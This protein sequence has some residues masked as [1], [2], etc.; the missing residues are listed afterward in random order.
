[1]NLDL[2]RLPPDFLVG[3]GEMGKLIGAMDWNGTP[4]GPIASWPQSLRTTVSLC[5][6]SN[7]PILIAWGPKHV[8]IYNDGYWPICGGKHPTSMGQ[9]FT[10]CLASAWPAIGE[11]FERALAGEASY[12]ENQ[13]MFLDRSGYLEETFFTFSFSPI[14]DEAGEVGGLFHPVTE[15]TGKML[16]ERRT[17]ALR[18]VSVR[19]AMA[20]TTADVFFSAA[21]TLAAYDL[22]LPFVLFYVLNGDKAELVAH[23]GCV[24]GNRLAPLSLDLAATAQESWPL[25][26]AAESATSIQVDDLAPRIDPS[27]C[28]PYPERPNTAFLLPIFPPGSNQAVAVMVAGVSSRLPLNDMYRTFVELIAGTV[29]AAVANATAYQDGRRRAEVLAE[30]DRTKTAF[31]SNIS[32]EF[33]TPL[34]LILGPVEDA[35][36]DTASSLSVG[37]R[38]RLE[39]V[40]RNALRLLKLVNALLDFSR[41]EAGRMRA[42]FEPIDLAT[43]TAELASNFDWLC[44]KAGLRLMIDCPPLP[45]KIHVDTEMWEKIV[46]NLISNAFKFTLCGEIAVSLHPVG[47]DSVELAVRDT[48][49]GIP[50]H[51]LPRLFERFHR[52]EGA[53][54][55]SYEGSGIGL[56]LVY[57]LV[58]LHNGTLLVESEVG[59]GS[60]FRV[61]LPSGTAHLPAD[62]IGSPRVDV[63]SGVR[64][65]AFLEEAMHWLPD[66][67][68]AENLAG[69]PQGISSVNDSAHGEP[70]PDA[71]RPRIILADDNADMRAYVSRILQA[72]GYDVVAVPD[73]EAALC[74]CTA[75]AV[76]DLV[77]TD[78]MMP[79]LDGFG[80]LRALRADP[81][82]EGLLVILLSARAGEEARVEGLVAGADDYLV[83]PFSAR[84]LL[85]RVEGSIRLARQRRQAAK[86][87]REL[88]T[89]LVAERGR[90]ALRKSEA[91]RLISEEKYRRLLDQARE[92]ILVL[93]ATGRILEANRSAEALFDRSQSMLLSST[94]ESLLP[95]AQLGELR[96]LLAVDMDELKE[97]HLPHADGR[98][99]HVEISTTRVR[100]GEQDI[101]LLIAR[102]ITERLLLEQQLRQAQK[103]EVVGQLTGGIA[104]DFNNILTVIIG[105]IELIADGVA[106]DAELTSSAVSIE[107][108]ADRGAQLTQRML[109]FAR[110][111]PLRPQVVD[112]SE[113]MIRMARI[114]RRT[115]GEDIAVKVSP[116]VGLWQAVA[117]PS[118]VED[119][120][121]NLAVNARDAMPQGGHLLF[122]TANAS[123][124]DMY[125]ARHTEIE[126]GD[127]A[128]LTVT[129]SGIGMPQEVIDRAFEPFFTTKDVGRGTGLGLSM[130][131]GFVKQSGGHVKIYSEPGHGT[132]IKI[133]LPKAVE[134][135][136]GTEVARVAGTEPRSI[137]QETIL[138]VE[139]EPA[140]RAVAMTHL[141][142][143]GYRVLE[144]EDGPAA[145][146]VL[147]A[148]AD[149]DLLFTDLI[150]PNGMNGQELLRR[151]REQRPALKALFTTGYSEQFIRDRDAVDQN[152]QLLG[153]PYRRLALAEKIHAALSH[154]LESGLRLAACDEPRTCL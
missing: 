131:Y 38:S 112:L 27:T 80:L 69:H 126:P 96:E 133:Y 25:R 2:E 35:L 24:A 111:Q 63:P 49:T 42:C 23:V 39:V 136:D 51:E 71:Q 9:D 152:V 10:E 57:E 61:F 148:V 74:A 55:R 21:Q 127:Y 30:L 58:K 106:K 31:F 91:L 88:Q 11:A 141:S 32:H 28:G 64:A 46:L 36:S 70:T 110:K 120:I 105:Q 121:L 119:A 115:L 33:R 3:G 154:D 4:L 114:L 15:Q 104:H 40:H 124:D 76:P 19:T 107:E 118:Q 17:R 117:D 147:Q 144:A 14:R 56:A 145:L 50:V 26:L 128:V 86:R 97:L 123:L 94:L 37:Q 87:E 52:I 77:L 84:E 139:D 29:T 16:S 78:V 137:R 22:D 93:D 99:R 122:E 48:G 81:A 92:S 134:V 18:D 59:G 151:A 41:I 108:A 34:A 98:E 101:V 7:F 103:M 90:A 89:E 45:E 146:K 79:R 109:A 95:P 130:V 60:V 67:Q 143:L 140:V 72:G 62:Q 125:A 68:V 150:M 6:C 149:I 75:G 73:G 142:A 135:A 116:A 138:V 5:V 43:F 44:E 13:R 132:A 8:Q 1:M 83:K 53:H 47:R 113:I 100:L 20:K 66:P 102:D 82:M 85:A 12:I 153:K 65:D 54:G 129:D